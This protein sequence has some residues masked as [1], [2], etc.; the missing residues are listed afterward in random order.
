MW[1]DL[2]QDREGLG[3]DRAGLGQGQEGKGLGGSRGVGAGRGHLNS[4]SHAPWH[5][6]P[7][8]PPAC[9]LPRVHPL[10]HPARPPRGMGPGLSWELSGPGTARGRRS[11]GCDSCAH[12]GYGS[13]SRPGPGRQHGWQAGRRGSRQLGGRPRLAHSAAPRMSAPHLQPG[14]GSAAGSPHLSTVQPLAAGTGLRADKE[15]AG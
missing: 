1:E 7:L 15:K 12:P 8:S 4:P 3:Q 10:W 14:T 6:W 11:P 13:N 9:G 2:G 5:R